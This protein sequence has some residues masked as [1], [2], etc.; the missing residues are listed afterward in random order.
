MMRK[1]ITK[2]SRVPEELFDNLASGG[3]AS[4]VDTAASSANAAQSN[5]EGE[6]E[7]VSLTI[8]I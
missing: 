4:I 6:A 2:P 8:I 5:Q 1:S 7:K 3:G